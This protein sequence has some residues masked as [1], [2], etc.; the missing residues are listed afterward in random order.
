M[1][2]K[3]DGSEGDARGSRRAFLQTLF[4]GAATAGV[5]AGCYD[6]GG[7]API[8]TPPQRLGSVGRAPDGTVLVAIADAVLRADA[9]DTNEGA[10]PWLRVGVGPVSRAVVQFD[11]EQ[12]MRLLA[13]GSAR[14]SLVLTI[15]CNHN[16]WGQA[17]TR[18]VD[19]HPLRSP[20]T[21][22][23]GRQTGLSGADQRRAMGPGAT[24]NSPTDG[25]CADNVTSTGA[26]TWSGALMSAAT[27]STVHTNHLTGDVVW[28]VTGDV[29]AGVVGWMVK[30]A[31]EETPTMAERPVVGGDGGYGGTVEYY[32]R[33]SATEDV[34][35]A[36]RL[37]FSSATPAPS[38]SPQIVPTPSPLIV[39]TPSAMP[40]PSPSP[41][42]IL[43][44][45]SPMI[46]PTPSPMIVPSPSAMP[47]LSAMPPAS[48]PPTTRMPAPSTAPMASTPPET[49][50][51]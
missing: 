9:R 50:A 22:G 15:A 34:N 26:Q 43:P 46:L 33:E 37:I 20:F 19:V 40:L 14:V 1:S 48:M 38:A 27:A 42:F 7:A 6:P 3:N 11:P 49:L 31:D 28:D 35:R 44:T 21:E 39:P 23:N 24:W 45:P 8:T 10:N 51:P 29:R 13:A 41:Q 36:P 17:D 18:K 25:D 12:V 47:G 32:A 5:Q 30:V 16:R 2:A 4:A